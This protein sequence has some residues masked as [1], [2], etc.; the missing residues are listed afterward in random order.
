MRGMVKAIGIDW[1]E[2]FFLRQKT[3]MSKDW[4]IQKC[5]KDRELNGLTADAL[6]FGDVGSEVTVF[7]GLTN[8]HEWT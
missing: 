6:V 8:D 3:K 5:G 1:R 7:L 4:V 2:I